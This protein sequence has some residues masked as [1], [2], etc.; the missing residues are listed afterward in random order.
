MSQKPFNSGAPGVR[1]VKHVA[2]QL[3]VEK[4]PAAIQHQNS[5]DEFALAAIDKKYTAT[6]FRLVHCRQ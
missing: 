6:I 3:R 4:E 2:S 5:V 1:A